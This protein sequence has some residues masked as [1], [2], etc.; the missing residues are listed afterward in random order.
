MFQVFLVRHGEVEGNS[1]PRPT[2]A[3]WTD[4]ALTPRGEA[5]ARAVG[6]RL[7]RENIGLVWSSD[8]QRA[9]K[10]G[11]AIA[12]HHGLEVDTKSALRE[13]NYGAWE[14]LGH[15]EIHRDWAEHWARRLADPLG[16]APPGGENYDALWARRE[17]AWHAFLEATAEVQS[18]STVLESPSGAAPAGVLVA[19]NGPLRLILCHLLGIPVANY[20]RL[21]T[22]NC[23][24]TTIEIETSGGARA[25]VVACVNETAHLR[26][27]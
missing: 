21:K 2:F 8:L 14:S 7:A 18:T 24:L 27:I 22:S 12:A 6:E 20:R 15:E 1:G 4:K 10:T 13:V 3:G 25:S 5:Q 9:R 23:G 11:E 19:H 26:D 16:V 17:P